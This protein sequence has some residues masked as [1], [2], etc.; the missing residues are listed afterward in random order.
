LSRTEAS[1]ALDD[2][3]ARDPALVGVKAARLAAAAAAGLP[4][5]PG[6]ILP[7][8]ASSEAVAH[9]V[10]ALEEGFGAP[11][12]Y[13]RALESSVPP[14]APEELMRGARSE[15]ELFAV[16]SSTLLDADGRWSGAFASYLDVEVRDLATAVRGCWASVFSRD[17]LE[18]CRATS[19]DVGSLRIGVL[20]QPSSPFDAGGTA[21]TRGDGTV[22]VTAAAGGPLGVVGGR[23]AGREMVVGRTGPVGGRIDRP[24]VRPELLEAVAALARSVTDTVGGVVIEWGAIGEALYLLQVGPDPFEAAVGEPMPRATKVRMPEDAERLARLVTA[25]PGP[26]GDALVLP[27]ALGVDEVPEADPFHVRT[28]PAEALEEARALAG[29]LAA[30]VWGMSPEAAGE[31][32][33]IVARRL[34][35]GRTE[36]ACR[37]I[38]A[39]SPP[40]RA[41]AR[42]VV[43]LIEGV[44]AF[45]AH[46]DT[47]PSASIVWR[48]S[49]AELERAITGARPIPRRGPGRWEPFVA[50]VVR[51][52]G[53]EVSGTPVSGGLGAGSLHPVRT[54]RSIGRP[55]S[56]EVL[57]ASLPLPHLA[58]LLWH[59]AGLVTTGGS[60][61][62]HL[63]EVARS[64]G[65]PSVIGVDPT[66]V[67]GAGS[68]VAVDGDIGTVS[69]LPLDVNASSPPSAGAR[70]MA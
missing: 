6:R 53:I 45:L 36:E 18:R 8:E 29:E 54:L 59:A 11:N 66:T 34:L 64:L 61:G 68:L 52:R 63:F 56:R 21:R 9:G 43:S 7:V 5:L 49:A 50:D 3:A 67:G 44:A 10:E 48:L 19:L 32:A 27:W 24:R 30:E 14:G 39:L 62:A 20:V 41:A 33:A 47:L 69:I 2:R 51:S 13:L 35:E 1:I 55:G 38:R 12:A 28:Q 4:V 42:R 57:V 46:A 22:A 60:P 25:F 70:V 58:P 31:R 16:R 65:V 15:R 37:E 17:V 23:D 40:D 26:L